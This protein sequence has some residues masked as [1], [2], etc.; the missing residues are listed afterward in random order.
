MPSPPAV[1]LQ[2]R[3]ERR[4][5]RP[6]SFLDCLPWEKILIWG[7]FLAAVYALRHFFLIIFLTFIISY[8]MRSIVLWVARL[9]SPH[10]ERVWLERGLALVAFALLLFG[11]YEAGNYLWPKLREQGEQLIGRVRH[12]DP[13]EDFKAL[14]KKAAG[15]FFFSRRYGDEKSPAYQEAF[16]AFQKSNAAAEDGAHAMTF[17]EVQTSIERNFDP[18]RDVASGLREALGDRLDEEVRK[19]FLQHKAPEVYAQDKARLQQKW[20]D[21]YQNTAQVAGLMP[22]DEFKQQP[23]FEPRRDEQIL[24]RIQSDV[25]ASSTGEWEKYR[26]EWL[27]LQARAEVE[28]LK[29]TPEYEERFRAYYTEERTKNPKGI[30]YTYEQYVILRDARAAGD[31]AFSAALRELGLSPMTEEERIA[32]SHLSFRLAEYEKLSNEFLKG[33]LATELVN[34]SKEYGR[35]LQNKLAGWVLGAVQY[36]LT[37]PGQLALSLLISFFINID[38]PNMRRGIRKL[39]RSRVANFYQEIAPGLINFGRLIGR[40]FQAQGVIALFN[41]VLTFTAIRLLGIQNEI[42]L[43]A[44]VFFCSFIPILGV[45]I[46]SVPIAIMSIVQPGGTVWLALQIIGAIIVIHFIETSLLNPKILGDMLHLHPVLVLAVLAVGGQYFGVW[47][48]LL[49]VPVMVYIIRFVI[50]DEG[51]PGLVEPVRQPAV[52]GL[53]PPKVP[54]KRPSGE[55]KP[56]AKLAEP[57]AAARPVL[58]R[59]EPGER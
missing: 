57:V 45:V 14:L 23:D 43:C 34:T 39:E 50:L 6:P 51:I 2:E 31:E 21:W 56:G 36:L 37:I 49:G 18:E 41:T 11:A 9:L 58:G 20:E 59:G 17:Q 28:R 26:L 44:I 5:S 42:F 22:L 35:E 10:R 29:S 7:L 40:A 32:Q 12:L 8:T 33:D 24:R 13:E 30:P 38:M 52:A 3:D 1:E 15:P 53:P 27:G 46:S 4:R 47:G 54:E 16:L 55:E 48:L 25:R 19:W